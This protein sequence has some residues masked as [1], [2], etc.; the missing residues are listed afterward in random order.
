M[1]PLEKEVGDEDF[2]NSKMDL[3]NIDLAK[4]DLGGVHAYENG[5]TQ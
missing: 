5:S 2:D 1:Y 3:G 4:V